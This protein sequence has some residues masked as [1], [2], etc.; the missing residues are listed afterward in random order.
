MKHKK[1]KDKNKIPSKQ[2]SLVI[3]SKESAL[4]L[5]SILLAFTSDASKVLDTK[6]KKHAKNWL[7]II[8]C[9]VPDICML[10]DD[11]AKG[12][13]REL[14]ISPLDIEIKLDFKERKLMLFICKAFYNQL[15]SP[16]G[17]DNWINNQGQEN[18]DFALEDFRNWIEML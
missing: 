12:P 16:E 4:N 7:E 10:V 5:Y 1:N 13:F 8:E 3:E 2:W 14:Y 9:D 11:T 15:L 17:R 6:A 18:Y